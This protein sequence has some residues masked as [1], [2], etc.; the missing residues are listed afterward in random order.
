MNVGQL[1]KCELDWSK[2]I[3]LGYLQDLTEE[4][5]LVRP[6]PECNHIKWQLGHLI[7]GENRHMTMIRPEKTVPL[8][9]GFQERYA[10]DK[11][12]SNT[13]GDFHSKAELLAVFEQ[14][15]SATLAILDT[16][17]EAELD[18]PS[19]MHFAPTI[20]ALITLE[21]QHWTMHA[22]QWAVIRRQLGK[23]PLF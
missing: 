23:P 20:G 6:H 21:A 10:V 2:M 17:T 9:S 4:D 15:R 12:K 19:G 1:V 7:A 18:A 8:P 11:C 5:L 14:Q 13:P 3:A 22:G 16:I